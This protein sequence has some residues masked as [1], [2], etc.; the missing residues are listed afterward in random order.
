MRTTSIKRRILNVLVQYKDRSYLTI[1]EIAELA[2]GEAYIRDTRKHLD[3][4]VR[5]NIYSTMELALENSMIILPVKKRNAET[6]E[7]EKRILGYKIAGKEDAEY[8]DILLQ[9]KE[10][11]ANAYIL[12]YNNSIKELEQR[13]LLPADMKY[14]FKMLES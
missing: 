2:Y 6:G 1:S 11:R 10:K 5:R 7:I 9:D 13:K 8:I 4:L 14:E 12:A 3:N